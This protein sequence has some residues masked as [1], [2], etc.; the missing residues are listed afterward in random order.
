MMMKWIREKNIKI[1][2]EQEGGCFFLSFQWYVR[3]YPK[4]VGPFLQEGDI[5]ILAFLNYQ[6]PVLLYQNE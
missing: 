1:K 5:K 2:K 4:V 3:F 6:N